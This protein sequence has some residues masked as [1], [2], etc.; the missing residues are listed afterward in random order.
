MRRLGEAELSA[1]QSSSS[2]FPKLPAAEHV[3][4]S[5]AAHSW[6]GGSSRSQG[7][8]EPPGTGAVKRNIPFPYPFCADQRT[9]VAD[10]TTLTPIAEPP[11]P[12]T[13]PAA[14]DECDLDI[15]L[16]LS[17]SRACGSSFA[18]SMCFGAEPRLSLFDGLTAAAHEE[19][20]LATPRSTDDSGPLPG[21]TRLTLQGRPR[22]LW[23]DFLSNSG[24]NFPNIDLDVP[25]VVDGH[26]RTPSA[27]DLG[28]PS[29]VSSFET[30]RQS[31]ATCLQQSLEQ[32]TQWKQTARDQYVRM[33][34]EWDQLETLAPPAAE[35]WRMLDDR[36]ELERFRERI[37][38]WQ[39]K[40]KDEAWLKWYAMKRDWLQNDQA[41]VRQH[42]AALR[43]ELTRVR[44]ATQRI[45]ECVRSVGSSLHEH[46]H[47]SAL[48]RSAS[49][50]RELGANE[51]RVAQQD[52]EFLRRKETEARLALEKEQ[53]AVSD[54]E[55][56][57]ARARA[58]KRRTDESVR[59]AGLGLL[60]RRLERQELD[61]QK[62]VRTCVIERATSSTVRLRMRGG[63]WICIDRAQPGRDL[64]QIFLELPLPSKSGDSW[65]EVP[66]DL[67]RELLQLVWHRYHATAKKGVDAAVSR[68]DAL[69][70][71]QTVVRVEQLPE[72]VRSMDVAAVRV[73]DQLRAIR[74]LHRERNVTHVA[75][76]L[77]DAVEGRPRLQLAVTLQVVHSHD[78]STHGVKPIDSTADPYAVEAVEC[79][80]EFVVDAESFPDT[81]C[82][83]DL[84]VRRVV[85]TYDADALAMFQR[86][87]KQQSSLTG[88][89]VEAANVLRRPPLTVTQRA[90]RESGPS[91]SL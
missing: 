16:G 30:L 61:K 4:A 20:E 28:C 14:V 21:S 46:D 9:F 79:I 26:V 12:R 25:A 59:S 33:V 8:I 69:H 40:C 56:E 67:G 1:G 24:I 74:L 89:L 29:V 75:A 6:D 57:L 35:C 39:S 27:P 80:L 82:C 23:A 43:T 47:Q 58:A 31:R 85:G 68:R 51:L 3:N 62:M 52:D 44:E 37:L 91:T 76:T 73:A 38:A 55:G 88:S 17:S 36:P 78:V 15:S 86:N 84:A 83:I 64:A 18:S 70:A 77:L 66:V 45:E 72:V 71:L 53:R 90:C 22:M 60:R 81:G 63:A 11:K 41:T 65:T 54:L 13:D 7:F 10:S 42:T 19:L 50:L 2:A 49:R 5:P 32:M 48:K 34:R 87:A